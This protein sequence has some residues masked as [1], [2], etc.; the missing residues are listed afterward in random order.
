MT[1][2]PRNLIGFRFLARGAGAAVFV[3]G[4]LVL[5]GWT[6]DLAILKSLIPGLTAMNPGGTALAFLLAGV[7]LWVQAS[8]GGS[9]RRRAFGIGCAAGVLL[10][11]L[12]RV[13]GYLAG[14]DGGPDQWLFRRRHWGREAVQ[15]GLLQPDVARTQP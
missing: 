1:D 6:F 3:I 10:I 5:A 7:S 4:G 2:H 15:S 13:A 14:V 9:S 11:G 8:S 12:V